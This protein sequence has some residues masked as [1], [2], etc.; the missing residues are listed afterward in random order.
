M[1]LGI[2]ISVIFTRAFLETSNVCT[3]KM[4]STFATKKMLDAHDL[5]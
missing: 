2:T 4:C 1:R 5:G 3:Q